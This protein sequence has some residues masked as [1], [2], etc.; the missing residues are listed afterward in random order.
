VSAVIAPRDEQAR[1]VELRE[2]TRGTEHVGVETHEPVFDGEHV[3][4]E[5]LEGARGRVRHAVSAE[6]HGAA[7][8]AEHVAAE[9]LEG[10]RG[11]VRHALSAL[12]G[13]MDGMPRIDVRGQLIRPLASY[14]AARAMAPVEWPRVWSAAL[15]VQLAHEASLVHDD[16]VDGAET[17]RGESSLAAVTGVGAALVAGD[18]LLA[19]AYRMAARTGSLAFADLFAEAVERTIAGE[20]A[21]GRALGRALEPAEYERIARDKAG[22]LLGCALA[23][24]ACIAGRTGGHAEVRDLYELGRTLGLLYQRLDDLLDYCPAADT[25]K[26]A[27]GDHAQ[28][29]WTWVMEALPPSAFT[30]SPDDART[31]LHTADA[32]GITPMRRLL[33]RLE[34]EFAAFHAHRAALLPGDAVVARLADAWLE[35]A[36]DAVR[37]EEEACRGALGGAAVSVDGEDRTGRKDAGLSTPESSHRHPLPQAVLGEGAGGRG[38]ASAE[39]AS[40]SPR[41]DAAANLA[42]IAAGLG[43]AEIARRIRAR[44]PEPREWRAYMAHH[45]RSFSFAARFFPADAAERV[46][47]VYAWCRVTDDLVDRADGEDTAALEAVLD[48][49]AALS[50]RAYGGR[51]T[52]IALLDRTMV[53]MAAARVPFTYAAELV[54]G[55]RMDLRRE[56]YPTAAALRVY[57]YRVAS[58][59]GLWLT[60]LFGVHEPATLRRA[61]AMGHAMQLT[62]ILRDVGEDA[63]AGRLY[64]PAD[65][66]RRHGVTADALAAAVAGTAPLPAGYPALVEELMR[67]AEE[68][69]ALAFAAIPRLP[70]FFQKPVAVAA[71]V[72]RG[73]HASIRRNG[74]DNLHL[75]ARTSAPEKALLA[76]RALRD[77]RTA[78]RASTAPEVRMESEAVAIGSG[79]A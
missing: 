71:H 25:G 59:V 24:P 49:W 12:V 26:P 17:R 34:A 40:F 9:T 46:A 48:E 21:Q 64:L 28:R 73:I 77:L 41:P 67:S 38:P 20:I 31:S 15:A 36:R 13:E 70:E 5:T 23:A 47:R 27:L 44:V 72:Y 30:G 6:T 14:G 39:P 74:Y 66:M 58:V 4:A 61:E 29:R 18:H 51:A 33:V 43:A 2:A 75:R 60:E 78:R 37:R 3:A 22:A 10:A 69:Y 68:D 52:G 63:R 1:P 8:D 55:M 54:E 42:P 57:T 50:R 76:A 32:D 56:S 19:W 62:N 7:C 35:R 53:E 11:R 45:S 16:I 79:P 65:L